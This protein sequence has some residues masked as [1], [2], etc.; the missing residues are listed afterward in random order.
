[1]GAVAGPTLPYLDMKASV[2]TFTID[3]IRNSVFNG[4]PQLMEGYKQ[5]GP[6]SFY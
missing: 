3:V 2:D 1:L 4:K 6:I 5:K